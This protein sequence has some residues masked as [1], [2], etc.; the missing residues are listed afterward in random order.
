MSTRLQLVDWETLL[1][2]EVATGMRRSWA[3][4]VLILTR[5][6]AEDGEPRAVTCA[7]IVAHSRSWILQ[8]GRNPQRGGAAVATAVG[9]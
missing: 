1:Q 6:A 8:G 2:P 5:K 3:E 4:E 7:E 9:R